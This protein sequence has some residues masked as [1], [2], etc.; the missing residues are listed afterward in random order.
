MENTSSKLK[1]LLLVIGDIACLY[2]SLFFT[3]G[4]RYGWSQAGAQWPSH[5]WPFTLVFVIWLV[6]F[7]IGELY[8]AKSNFNFSRLFGTLVKLFIVNFILAVAVFYF[9][10]PL[11]ADT[12]RPQRVLIID[13]V[14]ALALVFAYRKILSLSM[15]H[16]GKMGEV[17]IIGRSRLSEEL[18]R[19]IVK[20]PQPEFTIKVVE[21]L[22]EN[23]KEYCANE[24]VVAVVSSADIHENEELS[25]RLFDCLAWGVDVY[26]INRF[27]EEV[28]GKIPVDH[29]AHGWFLENLSSRP[30]L[31]YDLPK[32]IIDIVIA[33][34]SGIISLIPYPFVYLAIKLEDGGKI[35]IHQDRVGQNGRLIRAY[36]FRT[37][38]QN[39]TDLGS[40]D[41]RANYVTKVGNFLRKSR[42]D[43]LP[44]IWSVIKGDLSFIGPRPELPSGV[45][46][47]EREIPFYSVR[48]LVKPGLSGWAQVYQENH[49]HHGVAIEETRD[50]LSYDLYYVKNRSFWLDLRII[51]KTIRLLMMRKGI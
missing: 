30:R 50:K 5:F 33:V 42:I 23:F 7:Y 46:L 31:G 40:S 41:N 18:E 49:P 3:L 10:A 34:I 39:I 37:M 24:N 11:F 22:P 17:L 44:Q 29:I 51:L 45:A 16:T 8:D 21:S 12:I 35:F 47:Y 43:E 14:I 32:R 9:L 36:K 4:L 1:R 15:R 13:V 20:R 26:D 19:E 27:Y 2:L 28:M 38:A 25:R 6:G 48:H